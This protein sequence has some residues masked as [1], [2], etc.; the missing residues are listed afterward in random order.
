MHIKRAMI[1][2]LFIFINVIIKRLIIN[3]CLFDYKCFVFINNNVYIYLN[4]SIVFQ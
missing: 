4:W 3:S 2:F 1:Y